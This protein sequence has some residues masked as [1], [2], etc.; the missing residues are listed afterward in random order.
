[1]KRLSLILGC[2]LVLGIGVNALALEGSLADGAKLYGNVDVMLAIQQYA[3]V[4]LPEA[5]D[6]G[7]INY[8]DDKGFGSRKVAGSIRILTNDDVKVS[9]SSRGFRDSNDNPNWDLNNI[10]AYYYP[11]YNTSP[12]SFGAGGHKG[13]KKFTWDD[14]TNGLIEMQIEAYFSRK[15]GAADVWHLIRSGGYSDVLTVTIEGS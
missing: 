6:F 13:P 1:M 7:I 15:S 11:G 12:H 8:G 3:Q 14:A 4:E 2:M 5:L 9:M 10:V